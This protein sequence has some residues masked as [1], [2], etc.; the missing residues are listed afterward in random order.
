MAGPAALGLT[1]VGWGTRMVCGA[2]LHG[3]MVNAARMHLVDLIGAPV[4]LYALVRWSGAALVGRRLPALRLWPWVYAAYGVAF[5]VCGPVPRNLPGFEWFHLDYMQPGTGL[6][7]RA[8]ARSHAPS[9]ETTTTTATIT[10]SSP[11]Y[12]SG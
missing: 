2:C 10:W 11:V 1:A 6:W 7:R 4:A 12:R 5:V 9:Q 3:D 8:R